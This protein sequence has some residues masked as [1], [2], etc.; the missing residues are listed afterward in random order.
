[1]PQ[2]LQPTVRGT[3]EGLRSDNGAKFGCSDSGTW[4][5]LLLDVEF[6]ICILQY[7]Q[8]GRLRYYLI[9]EDNR[10]INLSNIPKQFRL[11]FSRDENETFSL[12]RR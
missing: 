6:N 12:N 8:T 7:P 1:M 3:P 9:S 5:P 2:A 11:A 10:D 4:L